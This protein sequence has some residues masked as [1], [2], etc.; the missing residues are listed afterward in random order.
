[1]TKDSGDLYHILGVEYNASQGDI[2]EAYKK[3][4]NS[5]ENASK[6]NKKGPLFKKAET[7][8]RE[9]SKAFV[10]L[11]DE[12]RRKQY[13]AG[14]PASN[15]PKINRQRTGYQVKFNEQSVTIFLPQNLTKTWLTTCEKHYDTQA[16]DGGKNGQQIKTSFL[17]TKSR[18]VLGSVSIKFYE[19]THKLLIQGSAYLLWLAEVYPELM[20]SIN[21]T[22]NNSPDNAATH[23]QASMPE[24]HSTPADSVVPLPPCPT[25]D[26][27]VE[28]DTCDCNTVPKDVVDVNSNHINGPESESQTETNV[29]VETTDDKD[30]KMAHESVTSNY[31]I[32]QESVAKLETCLA[33]SITDRKVF[34]DS[35][36]QKLS[37]IETRVKSCERPHTCVGISAEVK[38]RLLSDIARLEKNMHELELKVKSLEMRHERLCTVM[39]KAER[40]V[41]NV[42]RTRWKPKR[43]MTQITPTN[44]YV[45]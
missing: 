38:D 15:T 31:S 8:Y 16:M 13:D 30:S 28:S 27:P 23:V 34:E 40:P 21:P 9:V 7:R 43:R 26:Q 44:C 19:S 42:R 18:Q 22:S 33:E 2:V 5:Y 3:E 41:R 32:V 10:V 25:C 4:V 20:N 11:S 24:P 39:R 17:D 45:K 36:L 1:M 29:L 6:L 14:S 37:A 35:V 12:S